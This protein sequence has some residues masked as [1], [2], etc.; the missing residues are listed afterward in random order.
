[1]STQHFFLSSPASTLPERLREAFADIAPLSADALL[2]RLPALPAAQS[3][4]WL[5]ATDAQ[6]SQVLRQI[7]Q[8]KPDARVVLLSGV[9]EPTEGLRALNDGARGYTHAYGVP[10][11]LQ[12]V[13][14]VIEHGGL[15]VG[16][17][18]LQRLVGSTNAALAAQQAV[19]KAQSPAVATAGAGPNAWS[20]LSAREVQV[21]R[22]VAAGRSN[23]EVAAKMF[24]SE[25]TVKAHLGAIFEKLGVR[26]RLQ[27]VLR[28][29]ASPEPAATSTAEPKP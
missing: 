28:L 3:L 1:M 11:L 4:I 7:L 2:A 15:W 6:W 5:S 19:S 24:I 25:R 27:L 14:V 26:D 21:A 22:A 23:R 16:P 8:A 17:D 13:A 12:E 20:L 9:P 18:L 29:A 10:A